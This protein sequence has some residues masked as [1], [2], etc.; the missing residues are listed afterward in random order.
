MVPAIQLAIGSI[1]VGCAAWMQHRLCIGQRLHHL[2]CA[3]CVIEMDVRQ[4]EVIDLRAR[5]DPVRRALPATWARPAPGAGID[6]G[7]APLVHYQVAGRE[8][9]PYIFRIDQVEA[10]TQRLGYPACF[11]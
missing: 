6:E 2:A 1:E 10:I 4:E 3:A 5:D 9:R 7:G 8:P 11:A